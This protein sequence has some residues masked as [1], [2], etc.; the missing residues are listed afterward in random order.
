MA[1]VELV[2]LLLFLSKAH[3]CARAYTQLLT[4]IYYTTF[5]AQHAEHVFFSLE[6]KRATRRHLEMG[7]LD[8]WMGELDGWMRR[9]GKGSFPMGTEGASMGLT[10]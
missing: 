6:M 8:G 3:T 2:F 7:W 9:E 4:P 1:L 10:Q 5:N